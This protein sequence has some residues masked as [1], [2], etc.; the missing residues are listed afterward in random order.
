MDR[1][2]VV[3]CLV[4]TPRD[5]TNLRE[6]RWGFALDQRAFGPRR[7]LVAFAREDGSFLGL[8][9]TELTDPPWA[10]LTACIDTFGVDS[11]AAVALADEPV[12]EGTP[13]PE[14][15]HRFETACAVARASGVRLVDWM[16]CDDLLIRSARAAFSPGGDG[17]SEPEP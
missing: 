4:A 9:H 17:W 6:A 3:E 5:T 10:A 15:E 14:L 7:L 11:C 2:L 8:T 1:T 12:R 16:S 13:P